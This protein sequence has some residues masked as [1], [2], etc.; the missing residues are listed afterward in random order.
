LGCLGACLFESIE[1]RD[2]AGKLKRRTNECQSSGVSGNLC[3]AGFGGAKGH[4]ELFGFLVCVVVRVALCPEQREWIGR[5]TWFQN[6]TFSCP[7][8]PRPG[9]SWHACSRPTRNRNQRCTFHR[10]VSIVCFGVLV[11][12]APCV[13]QHISNNSIAENYQPFLPPVLF[14]RPRLPLVSPS[15][16]LC[17]NQ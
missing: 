10:R 5:P 13:K 6:T 2:R 8:I 14:L 17:G 12:P 15:F 1:I 16:L 7:D 4:V 3:L 9:Y 11:I